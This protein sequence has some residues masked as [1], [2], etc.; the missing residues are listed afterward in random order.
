MNKSIIFTIFIIVFFSCQNKIEQKKLKSKDK[1]SAAIEFIVDSVLNDSTFV[2]ELELS[3]LF[4]DR[5]KDSVFYRSL[6]YFDFLSKNDIDYIVWQQ[7]QLKNHPIADFT[8]VYSKYIKNNFISNGRNVY[9]ELSPPLFSLSDNFF[10]VHVLLVSQ[11]KKELKWDAMVLMCKKEY[12]YWHV[13]EK[14]A[15]PLKYKQPGYFQK[16]DRYPFLPGFP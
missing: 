9:I 5:I 16:N 10:V 2:K 12:G 15:S 11:V 1:I 6:P 8:S 13:M 14:F 7:K 4:S 3:P